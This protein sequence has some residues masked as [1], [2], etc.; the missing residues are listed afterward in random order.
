VTADGRRLAEVVSYTS[1]DSVL[2]DKQAEEWAAHSARWCI[3]AEAADDPDFE[4]GSWFGRSAPLI[5]EIGS[6]VGE[7]TA[8]LAA[9]RPEAN[10]LAFEVW[11]PGVASTF[12]RLEQAGVTNVRLMGVDAVWS[13]E[14][15]LGRETVEQMWTFFPDPWPKKRHD[16]RRLVTPRFASLAASRLVPGGLWRLATDWPAYAG[17]MLDV[18]AAEPLLQNVHDGPA[19]RWDPRPPTRFERRGIAAG[20]SITD[21]S[22]RRV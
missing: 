7:A 22:F 16:R 8:A 15:L 19:P 10:I 6:G 9:T 2:S 4:L 1:R 3:P 18:L 13:F 5:V 17:Q 14:H 12:T 11:Q 21:L 20:R